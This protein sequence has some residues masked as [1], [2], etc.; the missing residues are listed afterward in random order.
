MEFRLV[1]RITKRSWY[2][3]VV[4]M[5]SGLPMKRAFGTLTA[6]GHVM[7]PG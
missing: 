7:P 1:P 5:A 6:C 4:I 3:G 2:E